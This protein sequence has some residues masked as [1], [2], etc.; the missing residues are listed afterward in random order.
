M[1]E[2]NAAIKAAQQR[3]ERTKSQLQKAKA[4]WV[5]N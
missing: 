5:D 4:K 3:K 1:G 2:L